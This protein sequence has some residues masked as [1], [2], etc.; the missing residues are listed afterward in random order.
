MQSAINCCSCESGDSPKAFQDLSPQLQNSLKKII[1]S[2]GYILCN[3][4]VKD[5]NTGGGN[6]LAELY[7][8]NIKGETAKCEKENNIFVKQKIV[9]EN[10]QF[11]SINEAYY[12]EEFMYSK[13]SKIFTFLQDQANVPINE[14]FRMPKSYDETDDNAIILENLDK[15]GFKTYD[16]MRSI[17]LK[18]AEL[19]VIEMAKFHGLSF[20]IEQKM[21][22]YFE[23]KIKTLEHA[24]TYDDD[25]KGLIKNSCTYIANLFEGEIKRKVENSLPLIIE[26]FPRLNRDQTSVTC[27]LS[28]MDYRMN[29]VLVREEVSI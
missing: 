27:T 4:E 23:K 15:K 18:Y 14:R 7:E 17:P 26:K 16:R 3:V 29:N 11:L 8:I 24:F 1:K 20:V 5:L 12:N 25:W 22:E 2:E 28:H 21:P 13:L 10:L 6:F 19:S 9:L